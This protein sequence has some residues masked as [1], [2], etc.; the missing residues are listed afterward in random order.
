MLP[1]ASDTHCLVQSVPPSP[2]ILLITANKCHVRM[3]S[4]V[5]ACAPVLADFPAG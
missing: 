2:V 1:Q 3:A 5:R 4:Q